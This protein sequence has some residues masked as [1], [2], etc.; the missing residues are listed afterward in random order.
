MEQ[1][2]KVLNLRLDEILPNRFQPRI[3]FDEKAINE[4]SE[5]IKEHGVIQPI[6]VREIGDKYEIVAGERRYKASVMAGKETIPAIINNLND[7]D[8][9]EVALIEN[10]QRR[11]LTPIEEAVSYRK[12]LDMGYLTQEGL[13]AKLD[14]SQSTI[15][16]KLRLLNLDDSVQEALLEERISERHA[17]SLLK[18]PTEKQEELLT[19]IIKERLTVRQTD[20]V[21]ESIVNPNEEQE[22]IKE[23]EEPKKGEINMDNDQNKIFNIP[24]EP[25]VETNNEQPNTQDNIVNPG[26]VDVEEIEKIATDIN[27]TPEETSTFNIDDLLKVDPITVEEPINDPVDNN[28]N[29]SDFFG[30]NNVMPQPSVTPTQIK[31]QE[32][33]SFNPG[34]FFGVEPQEEV[35]NIQPLNLDELDLSNLD[36]DIDNS[37]LNLSHSGVIESE[38]DQSIESFNDL[39]NIVPEITSETS[40]VDQ[41]LDDFFAVPTASTPSSESKIE[42]VESLNL[43]DLSFEAP[44]AVEQ[45]SPINENVTETPQYTPH[46]TFDDFEELPEI[47]GNFPQDE[48]NVKSENDLR[49]AINTVRDLTRML[50]SQGYKLDTDEIDLP[51]NYKIVINIKK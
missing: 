24:S 32:E 3:R 45:E 34:R 15:A 1:E 8:S 28:E 26:F 18:L 43:D 17:R 46:Y 5:S 30:Q 16:N 2:Q 29:Q 10:V 41:E 12:I 49:V 4:L 50:E 9:A 11:D 14:K 47:S 22:K 35:E 40:I 38:L 39:D 42:E 19:R 21:I 20:N 7:Q 13:A 23:V 27:P 37:N 25:I 51:D 44:K 6:I 36:N 31:K 48:S 33:T